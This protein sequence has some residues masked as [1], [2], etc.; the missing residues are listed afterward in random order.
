M[1][2]PLDWAHNSDFFEWSE[3]VSVRVIDKLICFIHICICTH[4][5]NICIYCPYVYHNMRWLLFISPGF[6][7]KCTELSRWC[8]QTVG[9]QTSESTTSDALEKK[10][11]KSARCDERTSGRKSDEHMSKPLMRSPKSRC[12]SARV[13]Y[14]LWGS[15]GM[16]FYNYAGPQTKKK[17][18]FAFLFWCIACCSFSILYRSIWYVYF[19]WGSTLS[20]TIE[21][22]WHVTV[23]PAITG[24]FWWWVCHV[25]HIFPSWPTAGPGSAGRRWICHRIHAVDEEFGKHQEVQR[26]IFFLGDNSRF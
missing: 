10:C 19:I 6:G 24:W 15:D 23:M 21:M 13:Y 9:A 16:H 1:L 18:A 4:T 11:P 3:G 17:P 7:H 22:L 2:N 8:H 14:S 26:K 5:Y 20:W 12:Y 25:S